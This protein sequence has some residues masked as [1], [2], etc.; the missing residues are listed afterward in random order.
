MTSDTLD[1]LAVRYAELATEEGARGRAER[2]EFWRGRL[3]I[4]NTIRK[5][6]TIPHVYAYPMGDGWTR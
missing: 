2:A 6:R 4:V 1:S 5:A 3:D